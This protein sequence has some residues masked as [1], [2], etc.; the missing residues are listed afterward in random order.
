MASKLTATKKIPTPHLPHQPG[1]HCLSSLLD[2]FQGTIVNCCMDVEY[3]E[4]LIDQYQLA[5]TT[6]HDFFN[7]DRRHLKACVKL[8]HNLIEL[9]KNNPTNWISFDGTQWDQIFTVQAILLE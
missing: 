4:Y 6:C 2:Q 7:F 1:E 3:L 8:A 9:E 5:K